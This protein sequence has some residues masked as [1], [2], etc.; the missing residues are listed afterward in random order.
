[1]VQPLPLSI[2]AG[3]VGSG[4]FL[5]MILGVPGAALLAYLTPLPLFLAGLAFGSGAATVA[6]ATAMVVV[7]V[8]GG[9]VAIAIFFVSFSLPVVVTVRQAL[10]WRDGPDG[11]EWYPAGRVVAMLAGYAAAVIV[12][13]GVVFAGEPGGLYGAL[14]AV[15]TELISTLAAQGGADVAALLRSAQD[16]FWLLPALLAAS[17]LMMLLLNAVLAQA[18]VSRWG[19]AQRPSPSMATFTAPRWCMTPLLVGAVLSLVASGSLMVIGTAV[20]IVFLVPYLFVGLGVVHVWLRRWPGQAITL[21]L[22]YAS[23]VI[24]L[25][26]L[27]FVIAGLGL[28][29]EWAQLRRRMT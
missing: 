17:W 1:M 4:L 18:L 19:V 3:V 22:F 25:Y 28:I 14:E 6:S 13:A 15:M 7:G 26:P 23:L 16:M 8:I 27:A 9:G 24:F 29:E 20:L 11:A 10:L 5:T 12:L 21:G 2:L